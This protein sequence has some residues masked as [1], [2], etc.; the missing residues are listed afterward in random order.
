[1][2]VADDQHC[3]LVPR[4]WPVK[5]RRTKRNEGTE[6]MQAGRRSSFVGQGPSENAPTSSHFSRDLE[7]NARGLKYVDSM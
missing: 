4:G 6:Y 1:M 2:V 7:L 5:A 3:F